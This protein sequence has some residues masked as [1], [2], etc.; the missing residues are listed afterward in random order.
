MKGQSLFSDKKEKNS[1]CFADL[2]KWVVKVKVVAAKSL[3]MFLSKKKKK[4]KKCLLNVRF[5]S[6]DFLLFQ[7]DTIYKY[8]R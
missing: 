6:T 1:I 7:A 4:K 8:I 3:H 5:P 2:A